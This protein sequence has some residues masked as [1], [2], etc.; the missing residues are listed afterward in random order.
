MS[1]G[2]SWMNARSCTHEPSR[3]TPGGTVVAGGG[4]EKRELGR[5]QDISCVLSR[6][7][8]VSLLSGLIFMSV[9]RGNRCLNER[10]CPWSWEF[11]SGF[12]TNRETDSRW[13][14][15]ERERER[16]KEREK[17]EGIPQRWWRADDGVIR[18]LQNWCG[19]V[20]RRA[21]RRSIRQLPMNGLLKANLHG[22][23]PIVVPIRMNHPR[24]K[25]DERNSHKQRLCHDIL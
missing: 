20:L 18:L 19:V 5:A 6:L 25:N 9:Y 11:C 7:N 15:G 12:S 24:R 22:S 3:R 17:R 2:R 21:I 14:Q 8:P 1:R 13:Q 10:R 16:E 4:S 23:L